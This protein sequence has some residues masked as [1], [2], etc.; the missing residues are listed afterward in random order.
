MLWQ[1][2]SVY[3]AL[4][5]CRRSSYFYCQW[6]SL[7]ISIFFAVY[8][9]HDTNGIPQ[10]TIFGNYMEAIYSCPEVCTN[11]S[12]DGPHVRLLWRAPKQIEDYHQQ[13]C[14]S[15]YTLAL[16]GI[17]S[18]H[19]LVLDYI[20]TINLSISFGQMISVFFIQM[21]FQKQGF[22]LDFTEVLS[23]SLVLENSAFPEGWFK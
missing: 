11:F 13:Y 15:R 22:I 23:C 16:N 5:V 9:V 3:T 7:I 14:F 12:V 18:F 6:E 20:G 10:F 17:S 19:V 21:V 1:I 2:M 8:Q 4:L